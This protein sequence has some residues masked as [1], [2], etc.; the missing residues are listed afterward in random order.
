[1]AGS[2]LYRLDSRASAIA[3][4]SRTGESQRLVEDLVRLRCH[5]DGTPVI[6]PARLAEQWRWPAAVS[7]GCAPTRRSYY[8]P[9]R[10]EAESD[11]GCQP[12]VTAERRSGSGAWERPQAGRTE[13]FQIRIV[14]TD[15]LEQ[16]AAY[17]AWPSGWLS[18]N[19][20]PAASI[21]GSR[22]KFSAGVS[23]DVRLDIS[24]DGFASLLLLKPR[25][26]RPPRNPGH[27]M[28]RPVGLRP[29]AIVKI[30]R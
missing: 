25:V 3:A 19:S 9:P 21:S 11:V 12:P 15:S 17:H 7:A 4:R 14:A 26:D 16:V 27:G 13:P 30:R 6:A 18:M 23:F 28:A 10:S 22:S 29:K 8:T 20:T 2:G 5:S 1:M 24:V